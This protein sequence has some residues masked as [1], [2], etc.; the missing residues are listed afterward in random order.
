MDITAYIIWNLENLVNGTV[1]EFQVKIT[2]FKIYP[3]IQFYYDGHN[4][5]TVSM[6]DCFSVFCYF[7]A[8][9]YYRFDDFL[10]DDIDRSWKLNAFRW[11]DRSL[12]FIMENV[13]SHIMAEKKV[14]KLFKCAL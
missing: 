7:N 12:H 3:G 14:S 6:L 4:I 11:G 5:S 8:N 13:Y 10:L 1:L 2:L 9:F